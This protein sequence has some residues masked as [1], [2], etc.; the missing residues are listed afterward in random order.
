[1]AIDSRVSV[2]VGGLSPA[3]VD[4]NT[5]LWKKVA[6]GLAALLLLA[7]A[8]AFLAIPLNQQTSD[9]TDTLDFANFYTAGTI[10]AKGQSS[11]LYDI[12]LQQEIERQASPGGPFQPYYHPPFEAL[13]FA[14]FAL[15]S[16]PHAFLLW[17]AVNLAVFGSVIYLVNLTG[18]RLRTGRYMVWLALCLFFVLASLALGQDALLLAP[19]FLLAYLAMRERRDYSAG[20]ALGLGLFRFEIILPFV[21]VLLL[22]R[23]WKLLAGFCTMGVL[24]VGASVALVGWSG[25]LRYADTL[26]AVGG[27][28]KGLLSDRAS[29]QMMPSLYGAVQG[30]FGG[31][32]PQRL[33]FPAVV[34]STL[35]VLGWAAWEFRHIELPEEPAFGLEFSL[36]CVAALLASYHLF[37]SELTPLIVVGFL[38]LAYEERR[39]IDDRLENWRGA[40]LLLLVPAVAFGGALV[41]SQA[42]CV[43]SVVLLGMMIWLSRENVGQPNQGSSP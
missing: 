38:I 16:Y 3:A 23:R 10:V 29:A 36:A 12:Q 26:A 40:A 21:F 14:P 6:R 27:D 20:L 5:P 34:A 18:S 13:L 35:L 32:I 9:R 24:A 22:R 37:L 41:R 11:R 31:S 43:L 19:I 4:Q 33:G 39:P 25:I 30:L 42:F 1:L 7:A 28:G 17:A 8:C 2:G 15:L